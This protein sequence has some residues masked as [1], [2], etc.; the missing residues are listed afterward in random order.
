MFRMRERLRRVG[1]ETVETVERG[2]YVNRSGRRIELAG[3]IAA[4][5]AGT[6][7]HLPDDELPAPAGPTAGA[8]EVTVTNETT[9]VAARR[10]GSGVAALNFAS[11]RNPGGGFLTGASAQ[12]ED[13][14]RASALHACLLTVPEYYD[15]HR[16]L[17]DLRYTDRVIYS[18]GVPVFRAERDEDFAMLDEPYPV[19]FLTVAAPNLRAI[20]QNQPELAAS[21]PAAVRRRAERTLRVAAAH[22]HRELVL[23]AWGCGAFGNDPAVVAPILADALRA[24]PYFDRVVFAVLDR[25]T[26]TPT[27]AAF[28]R[29][30]GNG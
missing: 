1:W 6:R 2:S 22:G 20:A 13:L 24:Q 19:S 9:L 12:E 8:P 14:C 29:V 7:H 4:A 23:G 15:H 16:R 27:F 11:A 17:A 5:V 10:L 21:V 25:A 26:G 30:F 3:A 28:S 18:P